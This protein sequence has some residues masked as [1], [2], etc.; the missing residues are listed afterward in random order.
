M[1]DEKMTIKEVAQEYKITE[2]TVYEWF[3]RGLQFIKIGRMTRIKRSDL[4]EFISN[5][6]A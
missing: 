6:K 2:K 1:I 4:E 3:K 5:G